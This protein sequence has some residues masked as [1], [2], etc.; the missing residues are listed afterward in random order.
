MDPDE[1]K[2]V[3]DRLA[4]QAEESLGKLAQDLLESPLISGALTRAMEAREKASAVQEA[5]MSV[6]NLPSASDIERLTRRVRSVSQRLEGIE[7]Q[8]DVRLGD[9]NGSAAGT[10]AEMGLAEVEARIG[11]LANEVAGLAAALGSKDTK[12]AKAK[13]GAATA[14]ADVEGVGPATAKKLVAVGITTTSELIAA[15]GDAKGRAALAQQTGLS[16]KR[17][18][19]WVK[20][21]R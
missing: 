13:S 3:R 19:A 18:A 11:H 10:T 2:S 12:K 8:L 9:I 17:L 4:A 15:A 1:Q 20:A 5:A 21:A 16:E 6:L 14:V 7:D